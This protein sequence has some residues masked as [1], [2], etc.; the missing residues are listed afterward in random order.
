[1]QLPHAAPAH[2][3]SPPRLSTLSPTNSRHQD[4]TNTYQDPSPRVNQRNAADPPAHHLLPGTREDK[5]DKQIS[6]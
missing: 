5:K 4:S 6:T 2:P 1:M 3:D